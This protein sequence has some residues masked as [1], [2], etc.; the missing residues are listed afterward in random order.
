MEVT[1]S[2][3]NG[4]GSVTEGQDSSQEQKEVDLIPKADYLSLQAE[5]TKWRQSEI[6]LAVKLVSKDKSE[7]NNITDKKL[8]DIVVS[9]TSPY[10]S[11]E[12]MMAIEGNYS[13]QDN[14]WAD[15]ITLLKRQIKQL[16]YSQEKK[17]MENSIKSLGLPPTEEEKVRSAL[18][19]VNPQ[20]PINERIELATKIALP[21]W[22]DSRTLAY[23]ALQ[24]AVVGWDSWANGN[25]K[26]STKVEANAK[27]ILDFLKN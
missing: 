27:A 7:L 15:E 16:S 4:V 26:Q 21:Q 9:K 8:R 12:E 13:S 10:S 23:K 3:V 24:N 2:P 17:E 25:A 18:N 6:E 14:E 22:M 20:L 5:S 11:Y 19:A 1:N